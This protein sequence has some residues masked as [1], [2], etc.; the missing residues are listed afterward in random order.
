VEALSC[1]NCCH[2]PLQLGP[3]GTAFGYCTRHRVVLREPHLLTCGQLLRKDLLGPRA[4]SERARHAQRFAADRV[5]YVAEPDVSTRDVVEK[6]NGRMPGDAVVDEVRDFG[7]LDSKIASLAALRRIPG[8]R[9]EAAML[10]LGRGYFR[11]CVE[12]GGRWTAGVHLLRW[13]LDR[14]VDKP[15]LEPTDLREPLGPSLARTVEI[16]VWYV[17]A[18]R[19][20]LIT[21][22]AAKAGPGDPVARLSPLAERASRATEPGSGFEMLG[23]LSDRAPSIRRALPLSRYETLR[24]RLRPP[25]SS[26]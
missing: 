19:L 20:A 24:R 15:A 3:V 13:T 17:V 25:Q 12:H 18:M 6:P 4:A 23:W 21:E 7:E 22:I 14:L 16:A 5:A 2:N 9:A 1:S 11:N 8:A 26:D 10:S